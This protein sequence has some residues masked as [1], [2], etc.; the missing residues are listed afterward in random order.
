MPALE[1][2]KKIDEKATGWARPSDELGRLVR[3]RPRK[4]GPASPTISRS[5]S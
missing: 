3:A 1:T 5:P 4:Q 2:L